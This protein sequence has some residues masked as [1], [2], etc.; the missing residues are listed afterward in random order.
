MLTYIYRKNEYL[1]KRNTYRRPAFVLL[2]VRQQ[3]T[4]L[5][6]TLEGIKYIY[7]GFIN[8]LDAEVVI[9]VSIYFFL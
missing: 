7:S 6:L 2:N 5:L 4:S 3:S 8:T 9:C 1:K